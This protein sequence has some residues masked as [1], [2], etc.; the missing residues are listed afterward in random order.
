MFPGLPLAVV[1]LL[2]IGQADADLIARLERTELL[3]NSSW[4]SG[5]RKTPKGISCVCGW[6]A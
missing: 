6:M 3:V 4:S 2:A 5:S 1:G